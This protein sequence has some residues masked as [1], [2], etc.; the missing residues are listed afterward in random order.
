MEDDPEDADYIN[1]EKETGFA[2]RMDMDMFKEMKL[3]LSMSRQIN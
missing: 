2:R 1:D 3:F